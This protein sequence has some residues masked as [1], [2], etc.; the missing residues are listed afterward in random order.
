MD[1]GMAV[2]RQVWDQVGNQVGRQI[3]D[4]VFIDTQVSG[5]VLDRVLDWDQFGNQIDNQIW[6]AWDEI[7]EQAKEET[8]ES[9]SSG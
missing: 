8:N 6:W 3:C 2:E 7:C 1:L 5:E 9:T 4:R